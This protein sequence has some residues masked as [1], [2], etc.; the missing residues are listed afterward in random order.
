MNSVVQVV[1]CTRANDPLRDFARHIVTNEHVVRDELE[2]SKIA[3]LT[4]DRAGEEMTMR[5]E[6]ADVTAHSERDKPRA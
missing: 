4:V 2:V 3:T 6:L 5:V 1:A